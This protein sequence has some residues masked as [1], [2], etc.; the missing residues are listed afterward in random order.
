MAVARLVRVARHPRAR[1]LF[2]GFVRFLT[3]GPV[4]QSPGFHGEST[5]LSEKK[6]RWEPLANRLEESRQKLDDSRFP[7]TDQ[8]VAQLRLAIDDV[9]TYF[10]LH[11]TDEVQKSWDAY[12]E[13]EK[14]LKRLEG[15]FVDRY[16]AVNFLT[17]QLTRNQPGMD[18]PVLQALRGQTRKL[19]YLWLFE[20]PDKLRVGLE[21]E[22]SVLAE[23][24]RKS[25]DD[26]P[27]AEASAR[28]SLLCQHLAFA[29]QLP[30]LREELLSLSSKSNVRLYISD[31]VVGDYVRRPVSDDRDVNECILG[32]RVI[33]TAHTQGVV[34]SRLLPSSQSIRLQLQMQTQVT[35]RG[36]GYNGPVKAHTRSVG[37]VLTLKDVTISNQG[38]Q[39]SD[40]YSTAS[41]DSQILGIDHPLRI[42]RRIAEKKAAET[43]PRSQAIGKQRME[44]RTADSFDRQVEEQFFSKLKLNGSAEGKLALARLGL[45]E[46]TPKLSSD[47]FYAYVLT[48]MRDVHQT[49]ATNPPPQ[50]AASHRVILQLHESAIDNSASLLLAGRIV[51]D[52]QLGELIRGLESRFPVSRPKEQGKDSTEESSLADGEAG[53]FEIVFS[54]IRPIIFEARD[55]L[56]RIGMSGTRFT[57][58]GRDL[59]RPLEIIAEYAPVQTADGWQLERKGETK[60]QFPG[61]A[62]LGLGEVA[63]RGVLK[64]KIADKFPQRLLY[65]KLELPESLKAIGPLAI[66]GIEAHNG[67]ITISLD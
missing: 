11:G 34:T 6:S 47:A 18:L 39:S 58:E 29:Q 5:L 67:W 27:S 53:A 12:L 33:G 65:R 17:Y 49:S 30:E 63:L 25:A 15:S 28:L 7:S 21:N 61:R 46:P 1:V 38:I 2:I 40:A 4:D 14:N 66:Q 60:I 23:M 43:K 37:N 13:L 36:I 26:A 62:R 54:P 32:T 45:P 20:S 64:R 19:N 24:L 52:V 57:S 3:S 50:P 31:D 35:S 55:G 9:R 16:E 59:K 10:R 56:V 8:Q 44:S 51:S 42:V 48:K 41:L 22:L